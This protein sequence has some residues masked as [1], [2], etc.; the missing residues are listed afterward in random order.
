VLLS[1]GLKKSKIKANA[2]P[3]TFAIRTSQPQKIQNCKRVW[4]PPTLTDQR[5]EGKPAE[6]KVLPK[7]GLN[8]FDWTFVQG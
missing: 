4:L 2:K 6:N 5:T 7:A 1:Q 3:Y 8:G